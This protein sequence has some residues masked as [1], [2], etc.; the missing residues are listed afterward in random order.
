MT[1]DCH[2]PPGRPLL[3]PEGILWYHQ[4][5]DFLR[6]ALAVDNGLNIREEICRAG[7]LLY[8]RGYVAGHDGNISVR[9][10]PDRVLL[11][12]S[13]VGKGRLEPDM[14]VLCGLDGAVLAGDRHPSSESGMHLLLYRERPDVG[15]VVHAHPPV[16]TAFSVCRRGLAEPYLTETVSGLGEVPVA[17]FALPST[18]EVA[19]SIRPL[20]HNH[21]AVLLANHGALAWGEGLWAAFDRLETVEHTAKI[22]LCLEQLGGGVPLEP[23]QVAALKGLRGAYARLA[24]KRAGGD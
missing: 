6:G 5:K 8:E 1:E 23:E 19:E 21:S 3:A 12:P 7:R 10:G 4:G 20:I 11:T 9:V 16:S 22:Y 18:P 14:L 2:K 17:P 24:Q 15:A 13:G